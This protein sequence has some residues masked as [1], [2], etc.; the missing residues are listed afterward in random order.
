MIPDEVII[1]DRFLIRFT[2]IAT[3]GVKEIVDR[4][5]ADTVEITR[6]RDDGRDGETVLVSV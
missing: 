4:H 6:R 5:H 3:D 1:A 2:R